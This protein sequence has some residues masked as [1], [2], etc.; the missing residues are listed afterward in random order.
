MQQIE[1]REVTG[2]NCILHT[3]VVTKENFEEMFLEIVQQ[4]TTFSDRGLKEFKYLVGLLEYNMTCIG[5]DWSTPIDKNFAD[6]CN[7]LITHNVSVPILF[8]NVELLVLFF[9]RIKE[10]N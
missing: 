4:N 2:L 5:E 6:Y 9:K 3:H 8:T 7:F 1:N 10:Q